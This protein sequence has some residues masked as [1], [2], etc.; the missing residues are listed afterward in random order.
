MYCS[1]SSCGS[2]HHKSPRAGSKVTEVWKWRQLL[3]LEKPLSLLLLWSCWKLHMKIVSGVSWKYQQKNCKSVQVHEDGVL[4]RS[5]NAH[6]PF[7]DDRTKP[8][9]IIISKLGST[10]LTTALCWQNSIEREVNVILSATHEQPIKNKTVAHLIP[11]NEKMYH[12]TDMNEL[13]ADTN[14]SEVA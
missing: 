3:S 6:K 9:V 13:L 4:I 5:A 1:N 8:A 11:N 2:R 14:G 7:F 12:K 10:V